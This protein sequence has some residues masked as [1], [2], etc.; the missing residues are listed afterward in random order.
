MSLSL[1]SFKADFRSSELEAGR[2][3]LIPES[4]RIES[5]C[6]DYYYCYHYHYHPPQVRSGLL[7]R[8]VRIELWDY[9][10]VCTYVWYRLAHIMIDSV[11]YLYLTLPYLAR[12][13]GRKEGRQDGRT[14]FGWTAVY[15]TL[16]TSLTTVDSRARDVERGHGRRKW[17]WK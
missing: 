14:W 8:I 2:L 4:N 10:Y 17:K 7:V 3:V 1:L 5:N 9:S 12:K 13:E 15:L 11:P 6:E 16:K